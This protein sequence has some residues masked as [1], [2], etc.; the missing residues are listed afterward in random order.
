MNETERQEILDWIRFEHRD[1]R[2]LN[3]H[4]VKRR[5][6]D[7]LRRVYE[8]RPFW[9]WWQAI[10]DAGLDYG[11][12]KVE[13][14]ETVTCR[15]CGYEGQQLHVHLD[16]RHGISS[17]DYRARFPGAE[18]ASEAR[19]ARMKKDGG[20]HLLPHWEPLY[21]NEYMMDRAWR[22]H[23]LG[24]RLRTTWICEHD[25]NLWQHIHRQGITW[26]SFVTG[27]GIPYPEAITTRPPGMTRGELLE[28]LRRVHRELGET[29]RISR[30]AEKHHSLFTGV[31]R[32][33][34]TYEAAL[35]AAGVP[36]P[37][38]PYPPRREYS[39]E[40]VLETLQRLSREGVRITATGI[41][42]DPERRD[43]HHAIEKMGGY[44]ALREQLG[45]AKPPPPRNEVNHSREEV[46][47]ALR[48]RASTGKLFTVPSLREGG[49]A[50]PELLR[51]ARHHF[52]RWTDL[53]GAAGL[54]PE[55][56]AKPR[57]RRRREEWLAAIRRH[58]EAGGSLDRRVLIGDPVSGP[59]FRRGFKLFRNWEKALEAAGLPVTL[60]DSREAARQEIV[61]EIRA[62]FPGTEVPA[63]VVMKSAP[64]TADLLRRALSVFRSWSAAARAAGLGIAS[65]PKPI[66]VET[67]RSRPDRLRK[68][69]TKSWR[70]M[71]SEKKA[72]REA[73]IDAIR[74]RHAENRPL[75]LRG[76][77]HD[78]TGAGLYRKAIECFRSWK[79]AVAAAGL[80]EAL[81][82]PVLRSK[83]AEEID[84][85][86]PIPRDLY[87]EKPPGGRR[88]WK[89]RSEEELSNDDAD[90]DG[91]PAGPDGGIHPPAGGL[92]R[93]WR[94]PKRGEKQRH[95][96][97][98]AS[99]RKKRKKG[100]K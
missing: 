3:L 25:H 80:S 15:I 66:R 8:V 12:L 61:S 1:G 81:K 52:A 11:E 4:A 29:P 88:V 76:V 75:Y 24:H 37:D 69:S 72:R 28:G 84:L 9:G 22:Y 39:P 23:L 63:A 20:N 21:S 77:R 45:V 97:S 47:A 91:L 83:L 6:P 58:H 68:P 32:H 19:R 74:K 33:F 89:R 5:N 34:E 10:R 36:L 2:A 71:R 50:D 94:I 65:V 17:A 86:Y 30:L 43:L 16:R 98:K 87:E 93:G 38:R 78:P 18:I 44:P 42:A 48:K 85:A 100:R 7:L 99:L 60:A 90:E 14:E 53:L 56:H 57:A 79:A 41:R 67:V 46:I 73:V 51:S 49:D 62:A 70:A 31:R 40:E 92:P 59:L 35:E 55:H 64:E 27:L 13:L 82:P 26:E 96:P 54:Q 95:T